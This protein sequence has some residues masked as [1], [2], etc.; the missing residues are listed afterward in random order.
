V[1]QPVDKTLQRPVFISNLEFIFYVVAFRE[2]ASILKA[3]TEK[4]SPVFAVTMALQQ[5]SK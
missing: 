1:K 5:P 4:M 3:A 2:T